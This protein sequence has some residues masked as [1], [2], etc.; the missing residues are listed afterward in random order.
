[1][2]DTYLL[3]RFSDDDLEAFIL[4]R[5]RASWEIQN[6]FCWPISTKDFLDPEKPL[7]IP[8]LDDLLS[9]KN[10][11]SILL[12]PPELS[13][14]QSFQLPSLLKQEILPAC[15]NEM[16]ALIPWPIEQCQTAISIKRVQNSY[17]VFA[18][19]TPR[20]PIETA[21]RKLAD[22]H[23][24]PKHIFPESILLSREN[25]A[26]LQGDQ[27]SPGSTLQYE[28]QATRTV[29]LVLDESFPVKELVIRDPSPEER[30]RQLENI[31]FAF[32]MEGMALKK[33]RG[34]QHEHTP[35]GKVDG[36]P[37]ILAG[38][39]F[40]FPDGSLRKNLPDFRTGALASE[41]EKKLLIKQ[42]RPFLF[43]TVLLIMAIAF[44]G[45]VHY[46]SI[47]SQVTAEKSIIKKIASEALGTSQIVDP[48]AQMEQREKKLKKQSLMLSR[49]TDI[50]ELLRAI[51]I[52]P[53]NNMSFELVSLS[54]GAKSLNLSGKTDSFEHVEIIRTELLKNPH[55]KELS[56]QSARL[57]IDRKTVTFRMGG[58]HD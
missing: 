29:L 37:L 52:A 2:A 45:W 18:L 42:L 28:D 32:S 13:V 46:K 34:F 15:E 5:E 17:Q 53:P 12:W 48:I 10:V 36:T 43:L 22:H 41:H 44:D 30:M 51:S 31:F 20:F 55:I 24:E 14:S 38:A 49:G 25:T 21:I 56:V 26:V 8:E 50:I 27:K 3:T 39:K 9:G 35:E 23:L 7:K 58:T 1:M 19:T 4:Q 6:H 33:G 54:I 57:G 47:R 16:D 11:I 40:L